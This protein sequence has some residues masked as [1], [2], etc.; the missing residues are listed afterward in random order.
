MST[1]GAAP[2]PA[3]ASVSATIATAAGGELRLHATTWGDAAAPPLL[4]LHG[5][6]TCGLAWRAVAPA[7]ARDFYVVAPDNRGNGRSEREPPDLALESYASDTLRLCQA[8]NLASS[9]RPAVIGHSW[10]ANIGQILASLPPPDDAAFSKFILLDPVNWAM[11][12]AFASIVP[13]IIAQR[14]S[15]EDM[16]LAPLDSADINPELALTHG[17]HPPASGPCVRLRSLGP[18][19]VVSL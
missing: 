15:R 7:L 11:T 5:W 16:G 9:E 6:A 13:G 2:S 4:L 3:P 1:G 10:G 8:L 18:C 17:T 14:R 19:S 12:H